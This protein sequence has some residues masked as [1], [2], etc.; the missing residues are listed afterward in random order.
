MLNA[1]TSYLETM[2]ACDQFVLQPLGDWRES[3]SFV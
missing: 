2:F 3:E 1:L